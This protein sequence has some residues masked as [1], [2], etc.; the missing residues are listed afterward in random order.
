MT[1]EHV[2]LVD[3][4]AETRAWLIEHVIKPADYTFAEAESLDEAAVKI[5]AFKPHVI[6]LNL[7]ANVVGAIQF[8]AQHEAARPV[9]AL[10]STHPAEV[11][12][13]VLHAGA[14]DVL[15]KPLEPGRVARSIERAL[16]P[17][18]LLAER[19]TLREQTERQ[20]QEFNALYTIGKRITA[21]LDLEEVLSMVVTAAVNVTNA[22][23]GALMLLDAETGE[24]YLRA[25]RNL[26]DASAQ[27]KRVKVTDTLMGRV[28]NSGRPLMMRGDDVV[29]VQSSFLV[30]SIVSAPLLVGD[31]V[32]GVLSV[33]NKFSPREF[34]EHDVHVL[35][36]LADWAAIAI[37]NAQ[38]FAREQSRTR[39]LSALIEID[40]HISSTLDLTIVLERIAS[41][42]Q[43]L[44]QADDSEVYL[45]E[46]DGRTLRA[47]VAT[48]NY[49][50]EIKNYLIPLGQGI[51]GAIA[52]TGVAEL[53][54]GTEH[55][56]R[57]V[58]IPDVPFEH[59]ALLC[60]PLMSRG[61]TL[62]VMSVARTGMYQPFRSA[63]LDFLK[64]LAGQAA[65]AIENARL[66]ATEHQRVLE[67]A[68]TLEQQRELDRLK[69][70]FVQN[71]SHELRTPLAIVRGYAE[72][73]DSGEMG[74][75][76]E[77]ARE[78]V[79][80][81]ARRSRMLGKLLDD[82]LSILSAETGKLA[83]E[84]VDMTK[85][86]ESL[87]EEFQPVVKQTHINLSAQ[88][89]PHAAAV[90]G[91]PVQLRRVLD[92][93]LSN[94][95]KFTP[96]GGSIAVRLSSADSSVTLE[97]SDS[98]IGIPA[99]QLTRIF[100]R[101]YQVDGSTKRRYGGVGLGLS[102]VKEIVEGHG[103]RVSVES[104]VGKGSTFR[105]VLPALKTALA[106]D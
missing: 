25:S 9:I 97:V 64:A 94:A 39:E 63:E 81:I 58:P 57:N 43:R 65:I 45:L 36:T 52:E 56:A 68:R 101:F 84:Q 67:L 47:I 3:K 40:R 82:L 79:S 53:V 5:S 62:G 54:N 99:D 38:L 87:I 33:D 76:S 104:E 23:E 102:L 78:S 19:N 20:A 83:R 89:A 46:P 48:G 34:T 16:R 90:N 18:R 106:A 35:S 32:T 96:A 51:V 44:L 86:V 73:L 11:I 61:V 8:I 6:V 30:K 1:N 24:L 72:L 28:V 41:H 31:Q 4:N 27:K 80:V 22:E 88:V 26:S 12:Q 55:D 103:G 100:E 29:R 42:A 91:D 71:I 2:L 95:T 70:E 85:L 98:G 93:L 13:S 77:A 50:E 66:Y 49:A 75:L 14:H 92:N 10:A 69:N 17:Q 7:S 59:E 105:V 74:D 15:I 21:L 37:E 60:T